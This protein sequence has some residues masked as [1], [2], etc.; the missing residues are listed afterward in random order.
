MN[1]S[2]QITAVFVAAG[3]KVLAIE[4]L[5][6]QYWPRPSN[7]PWTDAEEIDNARLRANNPWWL[8]FTDLGIIKIGPRKRVIHIDWSHTKLRNRLPVTP[9]E[10]W[11]TSTDT[12]VH[13]YDQ[14]KMFEKLTQ[15]RAALK[16]S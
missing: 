11:I 10:E 13:V 4:E 5:V 14:I 8:V 15:L 6:N 1:N 7:G 12:F 3:F 2:E 9:G 16:D